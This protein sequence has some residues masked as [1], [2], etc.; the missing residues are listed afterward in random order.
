MNEVEARRQAM[1]YLRDQYTDA[2]ETSVE[3]HEFAGGWLVVQRGPGG[4]SARGAATLV[5]D[6]EDGRVRAFASAL[7]PRVVM[8]RYADLRQA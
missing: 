7:P 1:S 4:R 5:V 2:D 3:L 8:R 6:R